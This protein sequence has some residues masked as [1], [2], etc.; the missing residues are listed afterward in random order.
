MWS[1]RVSAGTVSRL[2]QKVYVQIDAWRQRPFELVY[3]YVYLDGLYLKRSW[4]GSY[5]NVAILVAMAVNE[6]G[7]WEVLGACMGM[8]EDT[9][10]YRN[11][12]SA[13]IRRG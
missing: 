11:I 9:V 5:E 4:G 1:T 12:L 10:A 13:R 7:E 3:P 6:E 8:K 2:N